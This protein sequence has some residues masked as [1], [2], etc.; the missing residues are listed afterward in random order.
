MTNRLIDIDAFLSTADANDDESNI[1]RLDLI[2]LLATHLAEIDPDRTPENDSPLADDFLL[3]Y[4]I[5]PTHHC[6]IDI[7]RDDDAAE[8]RAFRALH[9]A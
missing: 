8:C 3:S 2:L 9:F 5:C 4:D 7:C 6:D 1:D